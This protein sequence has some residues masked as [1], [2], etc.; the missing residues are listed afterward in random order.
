MLLLKKRVLSRPIVALPGLPRP[1][2]AGF[3]LRHA[4]HP[5]RVPDVTLTGQRNG[6]R[7]PTPAA[8]LEIATA[9]LRRK[10]DL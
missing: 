8:E 7:P 1:T 4:Q 9:G 5:D 6:R 2:Y 3:I 10:L